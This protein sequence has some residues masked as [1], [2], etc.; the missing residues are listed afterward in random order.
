MGIFNKK[1]SFNLTKTRLG[2]NLF[3]LL[4]PTYSIK[5]II[6]LE[7]P[8]KTLLEIIRRSDD[9]RLK[10]FLEE[11]TDIKI[12][13]YFAESQDPNLNK[14]VFDRLPGKRQTEIISWY[15]YIFGES[16]INRQTW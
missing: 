9:L 5:E 12:V 8:A 6:C 4:L 14:E 13:R 1:T 15:E 2:F 11:L 3:F 10:L 16:A 7:L